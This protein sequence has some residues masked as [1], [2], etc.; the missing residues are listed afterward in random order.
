M[1][2]LLKRVIVAII[3]IPLAIFVIF[4]GGWIFNIIVL[5]ISLVTLGEFYKIAEKKKSFPN[6]YIGLLMGT[7]LILNF[8]YFPLIQAILYA[9]FFLFI[10]ALLVLILELWR[11]KPNI[12]LNISS[13]ITGVIYISLSFSFFIMLRNYYHDISTL[14]NSTIDF[15][16][17]NTPLLLSNDIEAAWLVLSILISIWICDTAAFFAGKGFGKHKLFERISPKKTWEGAIAG[18][19][20]GI[21]AFWA[22]TEI[23]IKDFPLIS[24]II[25]GVIVGLFGQIGDLAESQ[26][27][28]DAGVKDSSAII[29][30]HGGFLDRFDSILFVIPI[31]CIYL[32]FISVTFQ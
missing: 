23:L 13:T 12:N 32:F 16:Q 4:I 28:R 1:S 22:S 21:I 3:A 26:L 8:S 10:F 31:I 18:F 11:K 7:L 19:I 17:I 14:Q 29:P 15:I 25:I 6:K 9:L 5:S 24:S 27:K 2:E 20:F 30:G